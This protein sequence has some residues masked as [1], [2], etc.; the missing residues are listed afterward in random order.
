NRENDFRRI[1]QRSHLSPE[2]K[3]QLNFINT[4]GAHFSREPLTMK[5]GTAIPP[6]VRSLARRIMRQVLKRHR[7][8]RLDWLSM[9]LDQ[10]AVEVREAKEAHHFGYWARVSTMTKGQKVEV[11][12]V[13]YPYF[14]SREG[15]RK[16]VL[17]V[18]EKDG[19]LYFGVIT[20]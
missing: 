2:V 17:Q 3:H 1:V 12:L 14:L 16:Q 18:S 11:P 19:R 10:R 13:T 15:T 8:P 6:E 9:M 4:W 7:Q 5:D 20:D